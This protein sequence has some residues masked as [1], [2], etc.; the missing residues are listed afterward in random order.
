MTI[1]E[2]IRGA[3]PME[4]FLAA[5]V[6]L[7]LALLKPRILP[8]LDFNVSNLIAAAAL[9]LVLSCGLLKTKKR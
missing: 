5:I 1:Q 3:L 7:Q 2:K 6:L 9:F 8:V 4:A